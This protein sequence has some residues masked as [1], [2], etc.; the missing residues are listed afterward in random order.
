MDTLANLVARIEQH[1]PFQIRHIEALTDKIYKFRT[2]Q[3]QTLI[4]KRVL[5][6]HDDEFLTRQ[7]YAYKA[8]SG[9]I[10]KIHETTRG[11][12]TVHDGA[13]FLYVTDFVRRIPLPI[14]AQAN[15]YMK[16]LGKLHEK[17]MLDIEK[18]EQ[19]ITFSYAEDYK[20]IEKNVLLLE[21]RMNA[22]EM[23]L[24]RSPFEWYFMMLYPVLYSMYRKS[25][26]AMK[27]F[28]R[29]LSRTKQMPVSLVHGDVNLANLLASENGTFL[30]NFESAHF[31]LPSVDLIAFL[32][33]YHQL[34]GVRNIAN[35]YLTSF[36][37][38]LI[39][40]HF[41]MRTLCVDLDHIFAGLK[42]HTLFDI[43]ILNERIAPSMLAMQLHEEMHPQ[44]PPPT[45]TKK[46][47]TA[48]SSDKKAKDATD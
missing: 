7:L 41:F 37:S 42:G 43:S 34:P 20:L 5:N 19:D 25:D 14:E 48:P 32:S 4:A 44:K 36:S 46:K 16:L 29:K 6:S 47:H 3:D 35:K 24:S 38:S 12:H 40:H 22:Y 13:D 31:D 9:H 26:E 28:Y 15:D 23:K 18:Q 30:I 39:E 2:T 27:K 21:E 10:L 17:T 8:L 45:A 33:H 1:Y 11:T